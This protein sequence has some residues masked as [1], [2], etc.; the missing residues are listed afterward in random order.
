[1]ETLLLPSELLQLQMS[2]TEDEWNAVCDRVKARC[3][4]YPSDWYAKVIQSGVSDSAKMRF[5]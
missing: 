3:G 4:G 5:S 1:M 2:K